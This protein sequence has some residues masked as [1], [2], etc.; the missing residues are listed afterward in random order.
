MSDCI[1]CPRSSSK[2]SCFAQLQARKRFFFPPPACTRFFIRR[3]IRATPDPIKTSLAPHS[4]HDTTR[5]SPL[6]G[7][8]IVCEEVEQPK[9]SWCLEGRGCKVGREVDS[10]DMLECPLCEQYFHPV[11][12]GVPVPEELPGYAKVWMCESCHERPG[13]P[14]IPPCGTECSSV[15]RSVANDPR[16]QSAKLT[17]PLVS[18]SGWRCR[19]NAARSRP[20][21]KSFQ[22]PARFASRNGSR[23]SNKKGTLLVRVNTPL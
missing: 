22:K 8:A 23:Q 20:P 1:V 19:I 15:S 3:K 12:V 6:P 21:K 18:A 10:P 2:Q 5:N 9:P 16:A 14:R 17:K 4:R 13:M 7:E 11:C